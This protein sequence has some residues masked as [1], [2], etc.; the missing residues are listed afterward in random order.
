MLRSQSF[1]WLQKNASRG[2][3]AAGTQGLVP[4]NPYL[5]GLDP[6]PLPRVAGRARPLLSKLRNITVKRLPRFANGLSPT[7][8]RGRV[9]P[10]PFYFIFKIKKRGGLEDA[11]SKRVWAAAHSRSEAAS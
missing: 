8:I 10:N 1:D 7:P 3:Y 5:G 4:K 9:S 2:A 11:S 6:L